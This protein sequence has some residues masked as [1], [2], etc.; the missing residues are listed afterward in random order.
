[1][2]TLNVTPLKNVWSRFNKRKIVDYP[3][4]RLKKVLETE[5]K[6]KKSPTWRGLGRAFNFLRGFNRGGGPQLN[7]T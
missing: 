4:V 5:K 3:E 7:L 1:M 6:V 2:T